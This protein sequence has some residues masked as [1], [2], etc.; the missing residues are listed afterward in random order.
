MPFQFG[1]I[2]LAVIGCGFLVQWVRVWRARKRVEECA[3]A[4]EAALVAKEYTN[5]IQLCDTA[6]E[7][8]RKLKL[9]PGDH[10]A[11]ILVF[12]SESLR[13][14]GKK[15]EALKAAVLECPSSCAVRGAHTQIAMLDRMGA[16][17]HEVGNLR[18]A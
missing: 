15:D 16:M 5:A 12:R 18:R 8:A 9:R 7:I 1:L 13:K 6:L 2:A 10:I 17:R 14:L 11:L 4:A 3:K